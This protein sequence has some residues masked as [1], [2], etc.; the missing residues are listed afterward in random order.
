MGTKK[1]TGRAVKQMVSDI[2][3]ADDFDRKSDEL[4]DLP[5]RQAVNPVFSFL[6]HQDQEIKWR[7]VTA[8]GIIVSNL[9]EKNMESAR[10]IMRRFMWS[11]NDESGG[12]GWGAPEAMAEIIA[13]HKGLAEE[14]A[15]VL[16][17]YIWEGGNYL[18]YEILQRGALWGIGRV[19]EVRP[20]LLQLRGVLRY[21]PP[22]LKSKDATVRGLAARAMGL[23]GTREDGASLEP[24]LSDHT[25]IE[26]YLNRKLVVRRV[27]D[28]AG[29]AALRLK[30][31]FST[32]D[33]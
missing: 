15:H 33:Q 7:A 24:L 13:C 26:I 22:Y 11:L 29:T 16:I 6:C 2:L 4:R 20:A 19:A 8:M 32:H 25:K 23:L 3:Y 27:S 21:L 30:K 9:A 14:Y 1:H 18:E 31:N 28:L 10:I 12:I 5:G 17:S